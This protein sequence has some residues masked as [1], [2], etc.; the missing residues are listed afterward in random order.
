MKISR[1]MQVFSLL[2]LCL[3]LLTLLVRHITPARGWPMLSHY[4][5]PMIF[6]F[7]GTV[8]MRRKT[9][10]SD[11][12]VCAAM[13]GWY[14]LSRIALGELYMENSW[15]P[16]CRVAVCYL[17]AFPFSYGTDDNERKLGLKWVAALY[18]A[19]MTL[20]AVLSVLVAVLGQPIHISM[21]E[22]A[23][24]YMGENDLRL[25]ALDHPNITAALFL[26]ALMLGFWLICASRR[27][28][29]A[30]PGA[31]MCLILYTG[32]GMTVSRTVMLQTALCIAL[33][34]V[35][36][37][38]QRRIPKGWVKA[39]ACIAAAIVFMAVGYFGFTLT[40]QAVALAAQAFPSAAAEGLKNTV[41]ATRPLMN[42]M[43]TLTGRTGIY[44][45]VI[46]MF[47]DNP[48]TL[49]F[50]D[51]ADH[52][53]TLLHRYAGNVSHT[54]NAY[55]QVTLFTGL[56]GAL[57]AVYLTLRALWMSFKV[58]FLQKSAFTDKLLAAFVVSLLVSVITE[59]YLFTQVEPIYNFLF[60]LIFGYLAETERGLRAK[61]A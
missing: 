59:V 10:A 1:R 57:I 36:F 33:V 38:L 27:R 42:D 28:W 26:I 56:P 11:Y 37:V 4:V 49:L 31:F 6:A 23:N 34:A 14:V 19:A 3:C 43:A 30:I 24:I 21:F 35:A 22:N 55:L 51:L 5:M 13:L 29:I 46:T 17:L 58:V 54:H 9:G 60:F 32:I 18:F 40:N 8:L 48:K 47:L 45:G 39:A 20:L 53:L 2:T 50:G 15:Q 52:A 44:Q 61:Q 12:I 41:V 25:Y 16:F 7:A